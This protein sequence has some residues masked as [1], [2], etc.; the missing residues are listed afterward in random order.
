MNLLRDFR[1]FWTLSRI[2]LSDAA[3]FL[4]CGFA[5]F[6]CWLVVT[7]HVFAISN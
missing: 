6:F 4:V 2:D 7:W 5:L 1:R 3:V